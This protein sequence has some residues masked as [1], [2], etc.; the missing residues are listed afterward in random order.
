MNPD[1]GRSVVVT[2]GTRGIGKAIALRLVSD[3]AARVVLGYM[4]NDKAA[5][6]AA[7]EIRG[8]GAEPVLVRGNV[9]SRR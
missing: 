3:G 4:R 9:G 6:S 8:A 2:G 1:K 7:E 5:E